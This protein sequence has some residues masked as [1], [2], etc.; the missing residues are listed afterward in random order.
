MLA[1]T[2]FMCSNGTFPDALVK[3][4]SLRIKGRK[5]LKFIGS[6]TFGSC[7]L[8]VSPLTEMHLIARHPPDSRTDPGAHL[9]EVRGQSPHGMHD[10]KQG[11]GT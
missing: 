4:A 3:T 2:T 5:L 10:L 8:F 1:V 9:V 6:A 11:Q 7:F